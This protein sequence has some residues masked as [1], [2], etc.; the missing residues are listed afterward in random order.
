MPLDSSYNS[1]ALKIQVLDKDSQCYFAD[2]NFAPILVL[3]IKTF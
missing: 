3:G 1:P 2:L